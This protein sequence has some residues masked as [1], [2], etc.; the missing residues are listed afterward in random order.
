[1]TK[2]V[3]DHPVFIMESFNGPGA[4]NAL[5]RDFFAANGVTVGADGFIA[6]GAPSLQ[7]LFLLRQMQ[8]QEQML[9][10]LQANASM[11]TEVAQARGL[12]A[13]FAPDDAPGVARTDGGG[14]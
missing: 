10:S 7:A 11:I 4:T 6:A 1:M 9:E 2:A 5:G 12:H 13:F 14:S 3:P 8:T